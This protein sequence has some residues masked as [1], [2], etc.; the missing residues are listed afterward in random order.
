M[1][2]QRQVSRGRTT[3]PQPAPP[4]VLSDALLNADIADNLD[5]VINDDKVRT[6]ILFNRKLWYRKW[7]LGDG[8]QAQIGRG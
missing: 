2:L 1:K 3:Q 6:K 5:V 8:P 4:L 7:G